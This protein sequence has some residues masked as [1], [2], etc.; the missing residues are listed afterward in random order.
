[1]DEDEASLAIR[2]ERKSLD[3]S[4]REGDDVSSVK[5]GRGVSHEL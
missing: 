4:I 3:I 2:G 5:E 1:L